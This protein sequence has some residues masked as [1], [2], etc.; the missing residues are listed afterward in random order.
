MTSVRA[1]RG[2]VEILSSLSDHLTSRPPITMSQEPPP[3]STH[4]APP[5]RSSYLPPSAVVRTR[6]EFPGDLDPATVPAEYRKDGEDWFALYNPRVPQSLNVNLVHQF[7]HES[8]VCCVRFSKDG[9]WLA[10]GCNRTAQI[11]DIRTGTLSCTLN[12]DNVS[13]EGEVPKID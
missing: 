12:D 4:E 1:W 6:E 8:V 2:S 11:F 10:T 5:A 13:Q 7:N 9:M 3:S